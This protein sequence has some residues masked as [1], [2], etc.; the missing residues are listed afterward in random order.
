MVAGTGAVTAGCEMTAHVG[1]VRQTVAVMAVLGG[2]AVR[3]GK[4]GG[5]R[6]KGSSCNNNNYSG[7]YNTELFRYFRYFIFTFVS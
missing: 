6:V 7:S 5:S 3:G 4:V 2:A 1:N